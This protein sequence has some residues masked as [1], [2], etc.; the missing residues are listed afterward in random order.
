MKTIKL[1]EQ[2]ADFFERVYAVVLL[3]PSGR[4]TSYGAIANYL[5]AKR[6]SRMVGWAMNAAHSN[7]DIPAHRVVNRNGMLTGKMHFETPETMQLR[8][9]AEGISVEK[10]AILDWEKVFW[11]PIIEL[12]L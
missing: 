5:G 12:T 9:E 7:P 6:S 4:A 1:S 2:N 11:N 8:L 3:I 10:D